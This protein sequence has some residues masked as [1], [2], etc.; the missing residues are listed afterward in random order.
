MKTNKNTILT[1]TYGGIFTALVI[2]L[3][4]LGNFIRFGTF[5]VSLVLIPIVLGAAMCGKYMG[6]WLGLVFGLVVLLNGD[7]NLFLT[8][9]APGAVVT[10]LAKGIACGLVTGLVYGWIAKRNQTAAIIVAA[11]VCPIVNTGVF[12]LGCYTFFLK[13]LPDIARTLQ[14]S[15]TNNAAFVFLVLIGGNF[16]VELGINIILSPTVIRVLNVAKKIRKS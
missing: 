14:V 4:M 15:F 16:L 8:F 10:V 2:I 9:H 1:L 6:A 13:N 12:A 3:Q 11:M 5:Q 7:A